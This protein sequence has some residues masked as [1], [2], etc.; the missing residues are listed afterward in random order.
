MTKLFNKKA[1]EKVQKSKLPPNCQ[2]LGLRF[3]LTWKEVPGMTR[4]AKA[5]LVV[6]GHQEQM[7]TLEPIDA[8]TGTREAE[9]ILMSECARR[10]WRL[11]KLD[12]P[13]AFLQSGR[14]YLQQVIAIRPPKE[15][16]EEEGVVT[17]SIC[18][19]MV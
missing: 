2:V 1:F 8:P 9:R 3:V 18:S 11:R 15:L 12:V 7:S 14:K 17:F 6:Q 19:S 10:G 16:N 4:E 13:R 5:R